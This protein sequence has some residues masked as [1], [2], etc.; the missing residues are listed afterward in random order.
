MGARIERTEKGEL[1]LW[2][3]D[4]KFFNSARADGSGIVSPDVCPT[5][6]WCGELRADVEDTRG[7]Q[8]IADALPRYP[9]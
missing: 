3:V 1:V 5:L 4:G 8:Q 6:S 9:R 2:L 7:R